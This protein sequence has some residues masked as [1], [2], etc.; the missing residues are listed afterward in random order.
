MIAASVFKNT[1]ASSKKKGEVGEVNL[2]KAL[3]MP[4][5]K[6]EDVKKAIRTSVSSVEVAVK[7]L[8]PKD[9]VSEALSAPYVAPKKPVNLGATL[10]RSLNLPIPRKGGVWRQLAAIMS[11]GQRVC[12]PE[13]NLGWHL[14]DNN[15]VAVGDSI[16][17]AN[18]KMSRTDL[19]SHD[20]MP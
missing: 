5:F 9:T 16:Q 11:L 7:V 17:S 18:N 12:Q 6:D 13:A 3:I 2:P 1:K 14:A 15:N 8:P 4:L 10:L 20:N 19:D